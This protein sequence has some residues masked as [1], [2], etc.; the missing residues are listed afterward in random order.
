M[1]TAEIKEFTEKTLL[2][3]KKAINILPDNYALVL[4]SIVKEDVAASLLLSYL[5]NE[6]DTLKRENIALRKT[7]DTWMNNEVLK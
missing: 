7:I 1:N 3:V 6:V 5:V 2:D 4:T